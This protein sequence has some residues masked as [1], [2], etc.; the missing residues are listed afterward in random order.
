M[1][2][3]QLFHPSTKVVRWKR[4]NV[5]TISRF[6]SLVGEERVDFIISLR[7]MLGDERQP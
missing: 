6:H 3:N 7:R 4:L 5:L 2:Q 1:Y